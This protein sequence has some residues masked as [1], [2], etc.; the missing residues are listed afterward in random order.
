MIVAFPNWLSGLLI[1]GL[2]GHPFSHRTYIY[3]NLLPN[4]EDL[5]SSLM[6]LYH[7]CPSLLSAGKLLEMPLSD[8]RHMPDTSYKPREQPR[9]T[10]RGWGSRSLWRF[11]LW[12]SPPTSLLNGGITVER[13]EHKTETR[14]RCITVDAHK[15]SI[16][17]T[18]C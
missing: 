12:N 6:S 15:E 5:S 2:G 10:I 7:C 17:Y 14:L 1:G 13:S 16:K 8:D 18:E 9:H 4:Q 3:H 11:C